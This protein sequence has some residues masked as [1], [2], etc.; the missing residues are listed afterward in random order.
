MTPVA[1]RLRAGRPAI[2]AWLSLASANVA[3]VLGRTGFDWLLIDGQHSPLGPA[4]IFDLVRVVVG[5]GASPIVRVRQL[6]AA[7]IA[8]A[9]DAGAHGVM[10]PMI[11]S[12]DAAARAVTMATYPPRGTRSIGGYGAH[13][14]FG[15]ARAD[16]LAAGAPALII[17]QLE[18]AEA[19]D[20]A[21]EILAV[22]GIGACFVGPQD[23]A[24]ALGV[25]PVLDSR[26]P[27]YLAA[28]EKI[29]SAAA[30]HGVP[31][32]ILTGSVE[33]ALR[34]LDLGFTMVAVSTDARL[35]ERSGRE[36]TTAARTWIDQHG[37][38][39]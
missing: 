14:A 17:I 31:V 32:G 33:D 3:D 2:G 19:V 36:V 23:L 38:R 18:D 29:R 39:G 20:R 1:D 12:P 10:V 35:L 4:E 5:T 21:D 9:L 34:H 24:A 30:R 25:A 22:E 7:D 6:D 27:A 16:Y 8:D 37:G 26:E 13:H 15:M 11:S 28:L